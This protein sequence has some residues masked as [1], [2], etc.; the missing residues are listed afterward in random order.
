[1]GGVLSVEEAFAALFKD[2][3]ESIESFLCGRNGQHL[4]RERNVPAPSQQEIQL[5]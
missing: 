4:L 1:M 5:S 2:Y 3:H